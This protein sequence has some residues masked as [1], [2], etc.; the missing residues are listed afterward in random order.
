MMMGRG[1]ARAGPLYPLPTGR[2]PA[3]R[4][5]P[6]LIRASLASREPLRPGRWC[7]ANPTP[8]A[9]G[10]TLANS[11]SRLVFLPA[12]PISITFPFP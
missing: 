1:R 2:I 12:G 6:L 3:G 5:S 11:T 4:S 8:P 7:A 9:N 10:R